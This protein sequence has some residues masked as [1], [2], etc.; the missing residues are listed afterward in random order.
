MDGVIDEYTDGYDNAYSG[1]ITNNTA[2]GLGTNGVDDASEQEAPPP[3]AA[4]LSGV[5]IKVRV[6]DPDSKQ[7]R[8]VT[9]T[10]SFQ[11]R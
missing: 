1:I 9:L 10:H 7:I 11:D 2:G 5:Q 4:R 6:F 3:Y 8:E